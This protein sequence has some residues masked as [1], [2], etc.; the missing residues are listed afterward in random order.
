[1][2]EGA[3]K[4]RALSKLEADLID[5]QR[6]YRCA[7]W[8][9]ENNGAFEHSRQTF[10]AAGLRKGI[11]LPLIGVTATVAQEV[12]IEA[13]EP[14]VTDAFDPHI[15]FHA[16]NTALLDELD[17]WPEPQSR[18]HFDGLCALSVLWETAVKRA[19]KFEYTSAADYRREQ[20]RQGGDDI[21]DSPSSWADV[22]AY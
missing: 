18:H 13:L 16:S 9:F 21:D 11:P 20:A 12:R 2:I 14:F 15:L 6:E 7:A 19:C 10:I 3:I 17:E 8:G 4:V 22:G 5:M 1:V